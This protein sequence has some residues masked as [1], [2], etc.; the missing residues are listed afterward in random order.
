MRNKSAIVAGVLAGMASP[1]TIYANTNYP[2]VGGSDMSRM[3]GD[4]TRVGQDFS[5]V[6]KREN[7]KSKTQESK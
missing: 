6:I 7:G 3:R 2:L 5:T 1:A 4:V